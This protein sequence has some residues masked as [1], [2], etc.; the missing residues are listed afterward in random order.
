MNNNKIYIIIPAFNEAQTIGN[1]LNDL[2]DKYSNIVVVD[3]ASD[4]NTAKIAKSMGVIVLEHLINRGQGAALKTGINYALNNKADVIVTFDADGQHQTDDIEKLIKPIIED[5]FDV[6]LGSRFLNSDSVK[7]IPPLKKIILKTGLIFTKAFS[8][9]KITD[10]HNG[11]RAFS[12][13]AAQKIIIRQD[14]MA[15]ASEILDEISRNNIKYKE[16]PVTIHY[17]DYS[18]SKGQS[19]LAFG[20]ILFK[21]FIGKLMK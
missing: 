12:N 5:N 16:I 19:S 4:D 11:L 1:V 13:Q 17:T 20:K 6:T 21:Y 8:H 18:K 7:K 14:R 3:D 15:H 10:T 9:L 2:K